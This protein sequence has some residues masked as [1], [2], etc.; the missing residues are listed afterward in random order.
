MKK[1]FTLAEVLITLGIIGIVAA[2][3][4]PTLI[5]KHRKTTVETSLKKFYSTINQA[6]KLSANENGDFETWIFPETDTPENVEQF[7]NKYLK[8]YIKVAHTEIGTVLLDVGA[9]TRFK[10]F[11][12]DG[13][14][15]AL[16][17]MGHDWFYCLKG[18]DLPD[19][20]AKLGTGCFMFGFYPERLPNNYTNSSYSKKGL[21]PYVAGAMKD[22][23]GDYIIGENGEYVNV[24]EADLY[25]QKLY[26]KIIQ[27]NGWT[28]PDDYPLKF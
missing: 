10:I 25:S 9:R 1:G 27:I 24:T 26:T 15:V 22:A 12:D 19:A 4:L 17:Y 3:T 14:A 7:F 18:K 8:P 20:N 13:S 11:L 28:I 21:E 23:N 2:L 16:G 6:M 5:Q